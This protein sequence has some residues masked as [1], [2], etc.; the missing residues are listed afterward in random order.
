MM[1]KCCKC[2]HIF[3]EEEIKIVYEDRGEFWGMPCSEP[4]EYS[5]C[6]TEDFTV[7]EESEE[8]NT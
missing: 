6:C 3:K 4:V 7:Y 5:P 2:G 8:D 1:F